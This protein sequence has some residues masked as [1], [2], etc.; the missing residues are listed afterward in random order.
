MKIDFSII[1][2]T[3]NSEMFL[4]ETLE[5]IKKQDRTIN[6]ECIFSDGGSS[7]NTMKII[8]NF[9]QIN[10]SKIIISD[11]IGLAKALNSGFKLANG[12]YLSYLNSDDQ[13]A[14]KALMKVKKNFE[15]YESCNWIVGLCENIGKK[16]ILNKLVNI[17]KKN[18]LYFLNFNLL[19]INNVISQPSVFWK[20]S[21]FNNVGY[22]N[23]NL[24]FNMDY[25]MWLRMMSI[26]HPYKLRNVLS[27]FRRHN[28]SLSHKNLLNQFIEKYKTMKRYNNNYILSSTHLLLSFLVIIIYK[29]SNY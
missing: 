3:L 7:D 17:Y 18:L 5:S 6:I 26:S 20:K 9:N 22:F 16:I 21:F 10:I 29:I 25:D 24:K 12:K 27:Y 15:N 8:E 28:Q 14:D 1:I 13:L 23:E 4:N 19:C 2:P 11:Q